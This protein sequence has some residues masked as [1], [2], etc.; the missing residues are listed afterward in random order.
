MFK[1]RWAAAAA[2]SWLSV[3]GAG[4]ALAAETTTSA[5]ASQPLDKG[6]AAQPGGTTGSSLS[7]AAS[8][9]IILGGNPQ[10]MACQEAAKFGDFN[11]TGIDMCS[12]ALGA[13]LLS[14]HDLAATYTDRGAIYMQHKQFALAKADFD[15]ALK[16]DPTIAN[17]Y[18]DRGGALIALKKYADA[19][20]DIDHGLSLG[21]DQP[22]KAYYNRAIADE[23]LK[24]LKSAYEDYTKASQIKPDWAAP[25]A[26][27]ARFNVKAE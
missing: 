1:N 3:L 11:G 24:D 27:L 14:Q 12:L 17:A 22:E 13:P 15:S 7:T 9:D 20:A 6:A 26:E 8:G 10:A 25:K 19:I 4:S 5:P 2:A 21:P 16:I 23:G 18:V